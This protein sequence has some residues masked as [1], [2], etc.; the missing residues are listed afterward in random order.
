M[1]KKIEKREDH[2]TCTCHRD[3]MAKRI[4]LRDQR[5]PTVRKI[6]TGKYDPNIEDK[7]RV[8]GNQWV[9]A[10]LQLEGIV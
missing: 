6:K 8:S 3:T 5:T 7:L 1:K 10:K 4:T 9:S 2:N